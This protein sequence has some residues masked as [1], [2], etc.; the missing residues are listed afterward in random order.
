M[1]PIIFWESFQ[2]RKIS[3]MKKKSKRLNSSLKVEWDLVLE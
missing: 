2:K 1:C 3:E